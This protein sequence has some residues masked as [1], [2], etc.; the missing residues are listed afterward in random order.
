MQ[1]IEI[2]QLSRMKRLTLNFQK[3]M[4]FRKEKGIIEKYH[5][6]NG[7]AQVGLIAQ[8]LLMMLY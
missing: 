5:L 2:F 8:L 4:E 6:Q 3:I 7:P 1:K